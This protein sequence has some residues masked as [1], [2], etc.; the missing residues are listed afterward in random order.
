MDD[1]LPARSWGKSVCGP[2]LR[3]HETGTATHEPLSDPSSVAGEPWAGRSCS[4]D[5]RADDHHVIQ[6]APYDDQPHCRLNAS[7]DRRHGFRHR[8]LD[9]HV[10]ERLHHPAGSDRRQL[11]PNH[12]GL[13]FP[14]AV[15]R[16]ELSIRPPES[17][18]LLI[19]R[20]RF[21]RRGGGPA[22]RP[23]AA[24]AERHHEREARWR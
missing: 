20:A 17:A 23:R 11:V 13:V 12:R 4:C 2:P 5:R 10:D 7:R 24:G 18:A 15:L 1:Y 9:R 22:K 8:W 21:A 3:D 14:H 6:E 19:E 16:L